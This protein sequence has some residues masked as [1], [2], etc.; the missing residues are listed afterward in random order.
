MY[1]GPTED[2]FVS[3]ETIK[4]EMAMRGELPDLSF[5]SEIKFPI[6]VDRH[7]HLAQT[8]ADQMKELSPRAENFVELTLPNASILSIIAD[9]HFGHPDVNIERIRQELEIIRNTPDSYIIFNGDLL[10]GILRAA[11]GLKR[12]PQEIPITSIANDIA[13]GVA[14][15]DFDDI[16]ASDWNEAIESLMSASSGVG[17]P[18]PAMK[19]TYEGIVDIIEK[20]VYSGIGRLLGWSEYVVGSDS[21]GKKKKKVKKKKKKK[22][23]VRK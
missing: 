11:L 20:D 2:S 12:W 6:D 13:D 1:Y 4:K 22:K 19:N 18:Y 10:D 3:K 9:M 8:R 5:S 15:I 21:D 23:K 17:I 14:K 7:L 16:S